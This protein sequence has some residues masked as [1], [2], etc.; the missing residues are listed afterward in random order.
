MDEQSAG[1]APERPGRSEARG[2]RGAALPA[3]ENVPREGDHQDPGLVEAV[4]VPVSPRW[5]LPSAGRWIS[6]G[7]VALAALTALVLVI[8]AAVQPSY[9]S[10][11]PYLGTHLVDLR[12]APVPEGWRNDLAATFAPSAPGQCVSFRAGTFDGRHE[13]VTATV[14]SSSTTGQNAECEVASP[15]TGGRIA[16]LDPVTGRT[17]WA[18]SLATDLDMTVFSLVWHASVEAGVVVVGIDGSKGDVMLSLDARTGATLSSAHLSLPD[19]V[20]NFGVSGSLVMSVVPDVGGS[21][22]TYSLR[23]VENLRSLLWTRTMSSSLFPELLPDRLV[24][25]LV[26]S[27]VSVDGVTGRESTWGA[28]LRALQGVRVVDDHLIAVT[29][30]AGVGLGSSVVLLAASGRRIWEHPAS[31]ITALAV[32]RACIVVSSGSSEQTC[33]DRSSGRVL[34]RATIP[35][36]IV[37][38]PEGARTDDIELIGPVTSS[39]ATLSISMIDGSSGKV[40]FVTT[41]PRGADVVGHS[42]S[43]GYA[44][45]T[46]AADGEADLTA[47]DLSSGA[48]LWSRRASDLEVWGGRLVEVTN[49]G[50]ARELTDPAAR[51]GPVPLPW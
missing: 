46:S 11:P 2:T 3:R 27:T 49:A 44:L 45:D 23:R 48:T 41:I 17:I 32:S 26:G 1:W 7:Y 38:T 25:P 19:E 43:T 24:V 50:V 14:P 12:S 30:P 5:S 13:V 9:G 42:V 47:F 31:D 29:T 4:R 51:S 15:A 18:R 33:L 36:A 10:L 40:R 22:V 28:D 34:W 21:V 37:G 20:I 16:M 39:S 6:A 35:G 8:G